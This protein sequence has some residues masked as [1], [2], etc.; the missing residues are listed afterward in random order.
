VLRIQLPGAE[1]LA[2]RIAKGPLAVDEALKVCRQI[3]EG[4]ESAH[5]KGI[6]HR[7]LMPANIKI[8][9]TALRASEIRPVLTAAPVRWRAMPWILAA[10]A[11]L[12]LFC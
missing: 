4:L 9:D 2:Q 10:V 8:Q 6:I 1:P 7:D 12:I 3:A 11:V 5:E